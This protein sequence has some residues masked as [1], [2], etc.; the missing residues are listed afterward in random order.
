MNQALQRFVL[1]LMVLSLWT[2]SFGQTSSTNEEAAALTMLKAFVQDYQSL[3]ETK[4]KQAVLQ[5]F[6]PEATSNLYVFNISG[7]S[8]VLNGNVRTFESYLDN[9][10]R[11]PNLL[12]VYEMTG[13]PMVNISG[14]VGTITYQVK[15]ELKEE[16]GIWVKGNELVTLAVE[17]IGGKWLI[18]HYTIVQIED[19][20]L[21]G[22]CVCEL[23]VGEGENAE[24]VSKTV[25]PSG[26]SYSTKFDNFV[27]RTAENGDWIIKT[28]AQSY[29]RLT[30]G[31]L[32]TVGEDG[33]EVELGIVSSRKEAVLMILSKGLY[34]DSCARIKSN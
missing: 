34:K 31:R 23:F 17:K 18:V 25:V 28:P 27:F 8:R 33:D 1:S 24:V 7:Q 14:N 11:S 19:E 10:L 16:D 5:H 32:V 15:Y 13:T 6:H 21:K 29:K 22:T 2:P 3:T 4:N 12:N 30:T 20:K 9:L 26:R